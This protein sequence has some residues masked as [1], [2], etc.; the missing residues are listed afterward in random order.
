[1]ISSKEE[2][3]Q[4][5]EDVHY[6]NN[7]MICLRIKVCR[8]MCDRKHNAY[9]CVTYFSYQETNKQYGVK[10]NLNKS[11]SREQSLHHNF[12]LPYQMRQCLKYMTKTSLWCYNN[13]SILMIINPLDIIHLH[14]IIPKVHQAQVKCVCVHACACVHM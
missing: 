8:S 7:M 2:Q 4:L 6:H 1:M 5:R 11:V 9:M 14:I 13:G 10:T 3:W 12:F